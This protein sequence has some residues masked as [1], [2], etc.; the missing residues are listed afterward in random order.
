MIAYESEELLHSLGDDADT[1]ARSLAQ[2]GIKG[3]PHSALTCPLARVIRGQVGLET[4][5]AHGGYALVLRKCE[6]EFI[7]RFDDGYYPELIEG[8]DK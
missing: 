1:I 2:R 4:A 6:R 3:R 5:I 8:G 7:F